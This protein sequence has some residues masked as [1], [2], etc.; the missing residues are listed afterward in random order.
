[1]VPT[2]IAGKNI[3]HKKAPLGFPVATEG[4]EIDGNSLQQP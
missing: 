3:G 2:K 4:F 1:M